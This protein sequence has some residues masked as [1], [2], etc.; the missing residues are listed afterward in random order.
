LNDDPRRINDLIELFKAHRHRM[1]FDE[2]G[3]YF[4]VFDRERLLDDLLRAVD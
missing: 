3:A 2:V 4:R 1:D